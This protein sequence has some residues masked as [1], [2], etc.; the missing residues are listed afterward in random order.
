[1]ATTDWVR[2]VLAN[3]GSETDARG[4]T[5]IPMMAATAIARYSDPAQREELK[6]EWE[7]GIR[8]L[9][10][11]A[12]PGSDQQL[13]FARCYAGCAPSNAR[14]DH[15]IGSDAVL[16]ELEAFLDG[17]F[18]VEGLAVDQHFRWALITALAKAGRYGDAEIDAELARD[19]TIEGREKAAGARVAQPTAEAKATGWD[20]IPD[21]ATP[22]ETSLQIVLSIFRSEQ[23]EVVAPYVEKFLDATDTV[24]DT[25]RVPQGLEAARVRLPARRGL[26]RGG[27]P[28]RREAGRQHGSQGRS[29]LRGRGP[30]RHR[31]CPGCS[32]PRRPALA[33][34]AESAQ[35]NGRVGASCADSACNLR[36]LGGFRR[37]RAGCSAGGRARRASRCRA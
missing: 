11:D 27:L 20:L 9:M 34:T 12:E 14:R 26:S 23:D 36:R 33:P 4:V 16:D 2:L 15:T 17:S 28:P 22:N 37:W 8:Q 25:P 3:I 10:L 1:M 18:T 7:R 5:R 24:I 21:P 19:N 6:A 13:T 35:T 31:P 32:G 30:R 29:A